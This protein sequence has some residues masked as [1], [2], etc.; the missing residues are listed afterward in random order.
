MKSHYIAVGD[1]YGPTLTKYDAADMYDLDNG[2]TLEKF[3][4][5]IVHYFS[6]KYKHFKSFY[7]RPGDESRCEIV[8]ESEHKPKAIPDL[9]Y[10]EFLVKFRS[11]QKID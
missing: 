3:R 8:L 10:Y 7:Y 5:A 2:E 6:E 1:V 4:L 9:K 11:F